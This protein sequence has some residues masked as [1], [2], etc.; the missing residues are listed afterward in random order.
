MLPLVRSFALAMCLALVFPLAAADKKTPS[1][2]P[3]T[4]E[5]VE[6]ELATLEELVAHW[7]KQ[8]AGS[9][10]AKQRASVYQQLLLRAGNLANQ[11]NQ[12]RQLL[13]TAI[14]SPPRKD[15]TGG[16]TT[17]TTAAQKKQLARLNDAE[18]RL[19]KLRERI[20][21]FNAPAGGAIAPGGAGGGGKPPVVSGTA[22]VPK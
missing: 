18:A 2:P 10:D 22:P 16:L 15:A 14:Q 13:N 12:L 4:I 17:A 3:P 21:K 11:I 8:F 20:E 1:P 9:S 7:E 6:K 5:G 19:R